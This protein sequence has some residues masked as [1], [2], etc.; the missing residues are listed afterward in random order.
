M[1]IHSN[2]T[3]SILTITSLS[4]YHLLCQFT[5]WTAQYKNYRWR[6]WDNQ[7][8][9]PCSLESK[10]SPFPKS[11]CN[12]YSYRAWLIKMLKQKLSAQHWARP[13][14][15]TNRMQNKISNIS[16]LKYC[17]LGYIKSFITSLHS[18]AARSL[19]HFRTWNVVLHH[20]SNA[21]ITKYCS[22][23]LENCWPQGHMKSKNGLSHLYNNILAYSQ[24]IIP[25]LSAPRFTA[26]PFSYIIT[27]TAIRKECSIII[28][29][30]HKTPFQI[31]LHRSHAWI[32]RVK[33]LHLHIPPYTFPIRLI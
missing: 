5:P 6:I 10:T 27:C 20:L 19:C 24:N 4:H 14:V 26:Q 11:R 23:E 9:T 2:G 32:S 33:Y 30:K 29:D 16:R 1:Q 13:A 15:S 7:R 31:H 28:Q 18:N 17:I 3:C 25:D 12:S 22:L 8:V 21:N